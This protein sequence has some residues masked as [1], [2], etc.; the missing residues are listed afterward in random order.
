[1]QTSPIQFSGIY[2]ITEE[3]QCFRLNGK[4]TLDQRANR[5]NQALQGIIN[6]Q[7]EALQTVSLVK[8]PLGNGPVTGLLLTEN[9]TFMFWRS[10][11]GENSNRFRHARDAYLAGQESFEKRFSRPPAPLAKWIN[12][13]FYKAYYQLFE[14]QIRA[15]TRYLE[16]LKQLIRERKAFQQENTER[17]ETRLLNYIQSHRNK[18]ATTGAPMQKL[19][20]FSTGFTFPSQVE[21]RL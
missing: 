4:G 12:P 6:Q 5:M 9:D 11:Y 16:E 14:D 8:T 19:T 20:L 15:K 13:R 2:Q 10:Q 18:D 7:T 17:F 1:M 3:A 21:N